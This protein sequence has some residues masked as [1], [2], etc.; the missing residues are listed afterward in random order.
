MFPG[1]ILAG[2][3]AR[4]LGGKGK[5]F[6]NISGVSLID[7]V[8]RK[9][10]T[11]VDRVAI[12]TRD[13]NSF[14][15]YNYPIIEDLITEEGGSGPLAG[16]SSAIKWAK[17]S[18]NPV[19]HVITVPVD[20]PLLPI[21]LVHRMSLELKIKKSDII[22]AS[23]NNNIYP[24]VSMWS[25]SLDNHLDKALSNGVRKIDA[26]TSSY[27]VSTV[28]WSFNDVDPFFNINNPE[29]IT[30]AEKYIKC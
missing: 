24:V 18:I 20:T 14:S 15:Q 22:F 13:K 17:K 23:S 30:L 19:S 26:F 25:L 8:L 4:R 28:D 2:G 21:D 9:I 6:I 27:N 11:Q 5:A 3:S 29:D 10:E 7:L 1:V 12:N 16:I